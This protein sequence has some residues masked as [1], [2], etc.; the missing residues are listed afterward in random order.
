MNNSLN[1]NNHELPPHNFS[2]DDFKKSTNEMIA[3]NERS[4]DNPY[5][6]WDR[7][8]LIRDYTQEE[9]KSIISSGDISAQRKLSRNYAIC[10]GYYKQILTHYATLLNYSGILIPNPS[11]G[12]SLQESSIS[13]RYHNAINFIDSIKLKELG[14]RIGFII[15]RDG[16]YYGAIKI[17]TKNTFALLDLP[18][19][20]CRV[21]F[22]DE[23]GN[24]L[25]EFNVEFFDTIFQEKNRKAALKT[26]PKIISSYYQRWSRKKSEISSWILLPNNV[27]V[28][29]DLFQPRPYFLDIIPSTIEYQESI[30]NELQRQLNERK[31]VFIQQIPHLNDGTLLFE[32]QEA[33]VMHKGTVEMLRTSNPDISVLTSYGEVKVE[34]T[35]TTDSVTNNTLGQ[36]QQNIYSNAGVSKEIFAATGSSSIP[37]SLDND[38][39]FMMVYGNKLAT[40]ITTL[41]N[42]LFSNGAINFNYVML[43]ITQH[44]KDKYIDSSFKLAGSGYSF[45]LPAIAQGFSQKD[46]V[47]VK[48]LENDL[49]DLSSKLIPLTSSYTQSNNPSNQ[50]DENKGRPELEPGTETQKTQ[51]NRESKEKTGGQ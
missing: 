22:R 4:Y 49:L 28:A 37:Y 40:F 14:A 26:Y 12:K 45:L 43:P 16:I 48:N 41:V 19:D 24:Y 11:F 21:R 2:L 23:Y 7:V 31:K 39:S 34:N 51:I 3:I 1:K 47:N 44:N 8:K 18:A 20:Y 9:I 32:P 27:G 17:L 38:T 29:F 6:N 33:E 10:N 13:K 50:S 46:F 36:M 42:T 35:K 30:D 25:V 15:L 5:L